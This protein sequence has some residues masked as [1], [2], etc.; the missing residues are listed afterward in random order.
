MVQ[1]TG[2]PPFDLSALEMQMPGIHR[3]YSNDSSLASTPLGS[4]LATGFGD[5]FPTSD[6]SSM[7]R[8]VPY[9]LQNG[10]IPQSFAQGGIQFPASWQIPT[11][12]LLQMSAPSSP[13]GYMSVNDLAQQIF[14]EP[15]GMNSGTTS[16]PP[17]MGFTSPPTSMP[18]TLQPS[19]PKMDL[20]NRPNSIDA[21]M[22]STQTPGSPPT[23]TAASSP[24]PPHG[25]KYLYRSDSGPYPAEPRLISLAN[26]VGMSAVLLSQCI[27]QYFRHVYAIRPFIHEPS[28]VG[29]LSQAEELTM[30]EKVLILTLSAVVV[31][32]D[33]P[34]VDLSLEKRH[35]VGER[36]L[37]IAIKMRKNYDWI[38]HSTLSAIQTSYMICVAL[39]E[40]KRPRS[41]HFYLREA[42][43]MAYDQGLHHESAY[44]GM[45]PIQAICARRTFAVLF[46]TERGLAILR[47]KSASIA[48]LPAV[49]S[50]FFDEQDRIVLAGF[51]ALSSLFAV[52]DEKF[53]DL[54]RSDSTSTSPYENIAGL[55]H[56]LN[57]FYV[58]INTLTDVQ[59]AD[60]LITH[61]WLRLIFWQASMRQGLVSS[62]ATD[63]VFYY[64][65]PIIIAKDLC[66]VMNEL[67]YDV[68]AVHGLGIFEKI[69]E[70][71]YTL[72]DALTI[73]EMQWSESEELRVLFRCL[74][75]SPNSENTY[76]R[77]LETK[78]DGV[79]GSQSPMGSPRSNRG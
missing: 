23:S 4:P 56:S 64:N 44:V 22:S 65:Y 60:V 49:P 26:E 2:L 24:M 69:F 52:L 42:I 10:T 16:A 50:D 33:S 30:E 51:T 77:M 41:H 17:S 19:P 48:S 39:F 5:V 78:V 38:E 54:W 67:S 53:I 11:S 62:D 7:P 18:R 14:Q 35:A 37:D 1:E 63:P 61:H 79:P 20:S 29:R 21:V 73:A 8:S 70:V 75:S 45:D 58:D 34:D 72:M 27:K 25:P 9:D 66:R 47:N 59:K 15:L 74:A 31:L 36:F 40:L 12:D 55:Q 6:P 13:S 32:Q 46:V 71:A 76:V 57:K 28:F 68:I 3:S 43:G